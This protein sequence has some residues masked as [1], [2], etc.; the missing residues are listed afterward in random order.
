MPHRENNQ[1][2]RYSHAWWLAQPRRPLADLEAEFAEKKDRLSPTLRRA[3]ERRIEARRSEERLQPFHGLLKD[4]A[5]IMEAVQV[6]YYGLIDNPH[7]QAVIEKNLAASRAHRFP[8]GIEGG[9]E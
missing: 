3:I 5:F 4:A 8:F 7:V 9:D 1:H 6:R 2:P